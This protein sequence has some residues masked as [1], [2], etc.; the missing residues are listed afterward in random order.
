MRK[1]SHSILGGL[2]ILLKVQNSGLI[3]DQSGEALEVDFANKY[4]GGGALNRGCVQ[5]CLTKLL[6][7]HA[8][9]PIHF[10]FWYIVHVCS[11]KVT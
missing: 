4:I 8:F 6:E 7:A 3:E 10:G 9:F 2:S 1:I 11:I 5:V